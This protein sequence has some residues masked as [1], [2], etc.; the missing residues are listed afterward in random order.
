MC[1]N[2]S[3][4]TCPILQ[5]VVYIFRDPDAVRTSSN[6]AYCT[7]SLTGGSENDYEVTDPQTVP[8]TITQSFQLPAADEYEPV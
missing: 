5:R 2:T 1:K 6:E 3:F 8:P 7:V 4:L